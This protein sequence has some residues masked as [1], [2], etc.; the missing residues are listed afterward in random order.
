VQL[1]PFDALPMTLR[2][3]PALVAGYAKTKAAIRQTPAMEAAKDREVIITTAAIAADGSVSGSSRLQAQG[4]KEAAARTSLSL[5]PAQMLPQMGNALAAGSGAGA[6]G[7]ITLGDLRNFTSRD[8]LTLD[9]TVPNRIS[10]PGPGALTGRFGAGQTPGTTFS[11]SVLQVERKLDFMCPGGGDEQHLELALPS[12]MKI[13]SLPGAADIESPYG[14]FSASYEVKDGKLV[15][16]HK[17]DLRQPATVCTAADYPELRKFA[18]AIDRE[19]K[20]QILYE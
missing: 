3:R 15:M 5:I 20:K 1:G 6:T 16:V 8:L 17:L 10:L 18:A 13:T 14:R 4:A 11:A 7:K 2:G 9:F 19:L 12:G